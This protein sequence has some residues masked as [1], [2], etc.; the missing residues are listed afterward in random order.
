MLPQ[1]KDRCC[2]NTPAY[3]TIGAQRADTTARYI[4]IARNQSAQYVRVNLQ[5]TDNWVLLIR[6]GRS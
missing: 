3:T 6:L 1:G 2:S 5:H 4:T